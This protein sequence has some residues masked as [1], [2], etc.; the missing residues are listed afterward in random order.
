M[1][2]VQRRVGLRCCMAWLCSISK[3]AD[4]VALLVLQIVESGRR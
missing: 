1:H 3:T 4:F 2:F